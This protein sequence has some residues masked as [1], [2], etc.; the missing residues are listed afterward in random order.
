MKILAFLAAVLLATTSTAAALVAENLNAPPPQRLT[1]TVEER[2]AA[3]N[4][5]LHA[6]TSTMQMNGLSFET[7]LQ[8]VTIQMNV[9]Y[10]VAWA[11]LEKAGVKKDTPVTLKSE[12]ADAAATLDLIFSML[13]P[14]SGKVAY[15]VEGG[16]LVIYLKTDADK[17]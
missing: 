15:K 10:E 1:G 4:K 14:T 7:L 12:G 5:A 16:K 6:G 8:F 3:I 11:D 17:K 2:N 13:K 9:D